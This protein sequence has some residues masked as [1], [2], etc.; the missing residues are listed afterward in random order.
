MFLQGL[1]F[2]PVHGAFEGVRSKKFYF[3]LSL[4][5]QS[6]YSLA[7]T[8]LAWPVFNELG[9]RSIAGTAACSV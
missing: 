3:A 4:M 5:H 2:Y 8:W 7:Q 1:S 6:H 9:L